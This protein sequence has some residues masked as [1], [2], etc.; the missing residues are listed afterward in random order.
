MDIGT[1][2]RKIG[3]SRLN[4]QIVLPSGGHEQVNRDFDGNDVAERVF[5]GPS[6]FFVEKKSQVMG[7]GDDLQNSALNQGYISCKF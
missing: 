4:H 3:P 6:R 7:K 1:I 2:C 5:V